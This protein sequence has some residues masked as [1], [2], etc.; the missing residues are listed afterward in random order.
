MIGSTHLHH[1]K[2]LGLL[3][4]IVL[5]SALV[6]LVGIAFSQGILPVEGSAAQLGGEGLHWSMLR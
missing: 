1:T 3:S 4:V 2:G 5:G 6:A